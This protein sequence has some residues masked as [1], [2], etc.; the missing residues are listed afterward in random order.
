MMSQEWGS[1][2]RMAEA[3]RKPTY[4]LLG[5]V[6]RLT[7]LLDE[8]TPAEISGLRK[9]VARIVEEIDAPA[10]QKLG[11]SLI[12]SGRIAPGRI[13]VALDRDALARRLNLPENRIDPAFLSLFNGFTLRR[14]GVEAKLVLDDATPEIDQTLFRN[15]ARG[16]AWF[17]EIKR[18]TPMHE[19]AQ[20]E[21]L[22]QR[23]IAR[24]VDLAFLAPDIVEAIVN[25]RQPV[26][27]TSDAL[28]K[29]EHR[30]LWAEQQARIA[31]L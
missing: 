3:K 23:R 5:D 22:S 17:E 6:A 20:R 16:W 31:A 4:G 8:P 12:E 29:S 26:T 28:I 21:K 27:L 14:R 18:G 15:L 11:A 2:A 25:G 10:G 13:S 30:M 24:L 19:I 1:D 9:C 7:R